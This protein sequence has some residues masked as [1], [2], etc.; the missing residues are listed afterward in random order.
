MKKLFLPLTV[1]VLTS[2]ASPELTKAVT[3]E[4]TSKKDVK[5]LS[6]CIAEKSDT[7]TFNG[8]RIETT[9]KPAKDGGVSLALINGSGYIDIIDQGTQR[10]IIYRGEAAETPW[11]K[12][13]NRKSDVIS[14]IDSC[15]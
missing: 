5:D 12:I 10:K 13:S 7:R 3:A 11:G 6:V 14:D 2:C 4:F 1:L 15:L 8:M 9:Q